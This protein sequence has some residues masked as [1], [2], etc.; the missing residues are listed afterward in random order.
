MIHFDCHAHVYERVFAAGTPRYLPRRPA[1]LKVWLDHLNGA[2][3][4]GGVIVQTSF[5]GTDNSELLAAL[6][7]LDHRRF[8][9]VAALDCCATQAE[10][11]RLVASGVRGVR[12]NLIEGAPLPDMKLPAVSAFLDRLNRAGLHLELHLESP[13]LAYLLPQLVPRVERIVVDHFGLPVSADPLDDP[14]LCWLRHTGD[15]SAIWVKLSAPYR[16][17]VAAAPHAAALLDLIGPERILWG[18]D[19]P[20]TRH[21]GR[22]DY[23]GT[24]RWAEQWLGSEFDD[25][26]AARA[27]YGLTAATLTG[28]RER[29]V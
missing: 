25:S 24:L 15:R 14:L 7:P 26:A 10:L 12:W 16:F 11:A 22:F 29:T 28:P 2:A 9:G 3:L 17:R 20:W 8:C 27:L 21:E 6:A 18:S 1:P 23:H 19:W 13:G 5:F 4:R